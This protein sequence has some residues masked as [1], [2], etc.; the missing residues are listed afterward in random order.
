MRRL[1][2]SKW[3]T[4]CRQAY[5]TSAGRLSSIIWLST[6]VRSFPGVSRLQMFFPRHPGRDIRLRHLLAI[7]SCVSLSSTQNGLFP[8]FSASRR[9]SRNER[10]SNRTGQAWLAG[11]LRT[12]CRESSLR[13]MV[14]SEML[15]SLAREKMDRGSARM[16]IEP[17]ISRNSPSPN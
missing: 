11:M 5:R 17:T 2:C 1:L 7:V 13:S 15:R 14:F 9:N 12:E 8:R 6:L 16:T 10:C 3:C 4:Q